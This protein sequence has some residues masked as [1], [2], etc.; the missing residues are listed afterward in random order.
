MA[1]VSS[2]TP[3]SGTTYRLRAAAHADERNAT[4]VMTV[5]ISVW[6]AALSVRA[7]GALNALHPP[8]L[9]WAGLFAHKRMDDEVNAAGCALAVA[10]VA[11][12]DD[13]GGMCFPGWRGGSGFCSSRPGC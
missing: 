13:A 10:G 11:L 1:V 7:G 8:V 9:G 5:R 3:G 4:A 12:L 6:A 2:S